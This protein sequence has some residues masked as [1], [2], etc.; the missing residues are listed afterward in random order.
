M[1]SI[2]KMTD[3]ELQAESD[4]YSEMDYDISDS[5]L[6]RW[7]AIERELDQRALWFADDGRV[8][9]SVGNYA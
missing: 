5:D 2:Y 6:E 9:E 4:R 1:A 3:A 8:R 7:G